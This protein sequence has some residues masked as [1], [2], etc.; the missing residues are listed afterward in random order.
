[1]PG[2]V[3]LEFQ[4]TQPRRREAMRADEESPMRILVMGDLSGRGNRGAAD[5]ADLAKRAVVSVDVDNFDKVLSRFAPSLRLPL[6]NAAGPP[7][8]IDFRQLEDFHPDRLYRDLSVFAALRQTRSLLQDPAT[9]EATAAKLQQGVTRTAEPDKPSAAPANAGAAE[10]QAAT[11]E[12]LLGRKPEPTGTA[13]KQSAAQPVDIEG[14]I[15]HIVAPHIVPEAS[16]FQAQYVASV[17]AAI[18]EQMRML[19]HHPQFQALES[20][21]RAIRWLIAELEIGDRLKLYLLD[22]TRD[23]LRADMHSAGGN[24]ENSALYRLLT[25]QREAV[26]GESWSLLVGNYTFTVQDNDIDL[27][28]WLGAIASQAGGPFLAAADASVLGCRSVVDTPDPRDW[29][30]IEGKAA[31]RWQA[32][33]QSAVAAWLGLAL[34]RILLRLPYGKRSDAVEHFDFE[35]L[36]P[37]RDHEAYLWGNPAMA[38]AL[39]IGR[40]FLERGWEMEPG[41]ERDVGDLPAH[42]Y[43]HDGEK[44]LQACAEAYL[45]ERA[46]EAMLA[47]GLMP[48]LSLNH[49]NAARL[50][51]FQSLAEPAQALAGPWR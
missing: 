31:Q 10:D 25:Q 48:F 38:C 20:A 16:P 39:L 9:F 41:D 6:G 3:G 51:R 30:A 32:L 4:F 40:T 27:L 17:D 18:G 22:V 45:S 1:M 2:R 21:W 7:M 5:A 46:G 47:R 42:V 8:T 43:E 26:D 49:Q 15:R 19:L 35:E 23:E 28:A 50:L 36:T 34:P 44:R 29:P 13:P 24:P 11:L 12:R 14:L 33:R 37:A